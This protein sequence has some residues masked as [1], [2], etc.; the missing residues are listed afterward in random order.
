MRVMLTKEKK[1]LLAQRLASIGARTVGPLPLPGH[2]DPVREFRAATPS[3]DGITMLRSLSAGERAELARKCV[4]RRFSAGTVIAERFSQGNSV[5]FLIE[6][7]ARILHNAGESGEVTIATVA[8]GNALGEI[9]AVDA[10]GR[11]A[12]IVAE[13]DC[14]VLELPADEFDTLL[15]T[16]AQ[17]GRDL[18]RRW[19]CLIR[20]LDEKVSTLASGS[21]EQRIYAELVRL[22]KSTSEGRDRWIVPDVPSHREIA[23]WAQTSREVVIRLL[24]ELSREGLIERRGKTLHIYGYDVVRERAASGEAASTACERLSA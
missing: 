14:L 18:L 13:T 24:A 10:Q 20:Q 21:P 9:A 12:G 8:A 4:T 23:L 5:F 3:L 6:G 15:N 22:A 11:S 1:E 16:H 7:L 17:V 19:A 2:D